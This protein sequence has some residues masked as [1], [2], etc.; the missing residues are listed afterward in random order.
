M[1]LRITSPAFDDGDRIP[2]KYTGD[3]ANISPPLEW[4]NVPDGCQTLTLICDDPDAPVGTFVHW[5]FYNIP[6]D[7]G[8]LPENMPCEENVF[9][10]AE[11][12]VN[13]FGDIG[14][15][16]P[17]PPPGGPHRYFFKLYA[18]DTVLPLSPRATKQ[19][20]VDGMQ[21]HVLDQAEVIGRYTR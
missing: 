5:V 21:G 10:S 11:Q 2:K 6:A 3:G 9:G 20:V 15:G 13:D 1:A 8:E 7:H 14:Y 4:A 19:Q 16:G 12:G 18:L 17:A